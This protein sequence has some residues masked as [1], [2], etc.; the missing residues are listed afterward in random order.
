MSSPEAIETTSSV[1]DSCD[2]KYLRELREAS[3]MDLAVLAR[4]VEI[5]LVAADLA[6]SLRPSLVGAVAVS[7]V[8]VNRL[9]LHVVKTLKS[10][11]DSTCQAS[12]LAHKS[13]SM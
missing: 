6:T 12:C 5:H 4:A 8:N 3:G 10:L 11:H 1:Y 7:A 9:V 13:L 2:P